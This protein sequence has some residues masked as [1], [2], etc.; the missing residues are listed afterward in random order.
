MPAVKRPLKLDRRTAS[1]RVAEVDFSGAPKEFLFYNCHQVQK[2]GGFITLILGFA[3]PGAPIKTVFLG[4]IWH[5]DLASQVPD[6]QKYIEKIGAPYPGE[7]KGALSFANFSTAPVSFNQ[8]ECAAR[9]GWSEISIRQF[10]HKAAI[11][12]KD[13][14]AESDTVTGVIHGL[15]VSDIDTHKR[16]IDDLIIHSG[17]P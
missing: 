2:Y 5:L 8:I 9:G 11:D 7:S 6:L 14:N 16:L 15:Y 13:P 4:V 1:K 17:R 3:D 10:S 12:L